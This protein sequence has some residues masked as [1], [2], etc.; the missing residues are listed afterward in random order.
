MRLILGKANA[1]HATLTIDGTDKVIEIT[2]AE[3][4]TAMA[5][6]IARA[7][8]RDRHFEAL[9][10]A[11]TPFR[12]NEMGDKLVGMIDVRENGGE[13]AQSNLVRLVAMIDVI[14]DAVARHDDDGDE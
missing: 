1:T 10:A 8:N 7:F 14:L 9:V 11:L 12:S 13:Q 2:V 5:M 6:R 4:A 3:N